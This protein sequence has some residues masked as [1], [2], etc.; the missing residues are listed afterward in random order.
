MPAGSKVVVQWHE[1]FKNRTNAG[2]AY[3]ALSRS[4]QLNDIYIKGTLERDGIHA[5]TDALEETNRLQAIFD[6]NVVK[7][8]E[9]ADEYW[10]ISYL[11]VRSLNCHKND[12]AKDNFLMSADVFSLG[13]THL[14]QGD[15]IHFD[16]F[17]GNFASHG[18]GKGVST[19]YS[20]ECTMVNSIASEKYSGIHLRFDKF[21]GIFLY[22]S[23]GCDKEEILGH[24]ETWIVDSTPTFIMGDF[25]IDF[26]KGDK[27]VK[28][29]E[30][31]GFEQL[32]KEATRT[33]GYLIDHIY[34]NK[35]LMSLN[36]T[37][38][39]DSAYYSDHDIITIH[40]PK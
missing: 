3:V 33:S 19:F 15:E 35:E 4:E 25:N 22:L 8:Y 2:L 6:Q 37:T 30:N 17:T 39:I 16:G 10:Q 14:E 26:F 9:R 5:S 29:L 23:S 38:Q 20:T 24:I 1:M 32:I 31:F 34:V 21:D 13:E 40:I 18:K 7:S 11:N 12:V 27:L 36:V 28:A